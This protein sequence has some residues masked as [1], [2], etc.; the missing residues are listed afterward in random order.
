ML[1]VIVAIIIIPTVYTTL[2]L[3]S[4]WDPY[5]KVDNLPVA[6]VNQDKEVTFENQVL[7]IGDDLV[8]NLKDNDSLKF[9]F[10]DSTTANQGLEDGT[11]Y[12]VITIPQD[13]SFNATTVMDKNPQKMEL[14]YK[15]NPAHNYIASKMGENAV[16]RI[17]ESLNTEV[18]KVYLDTISDLFTEASDGMQKASDGAEKLQDGL[19]KVSDG[20]Q[21][22][23]EGVNKIATGASQ[24]AEN[25][26]AL[27]HGISQLSSGVHELSDGSKKLINGLNTLSGSIHS[28]IPSGSDIAALGK[29]LDAYKSGINQLNTALNNFSFGNQGK[30]IGDSLSNI[31]S[32]TQAAAADVSAIG[33]AVKTL[34]QAN[35]TKEQALALQTIVASATDLGGHLSTIA[36]DTKSVGNSLTSLTTGMSKINELKTAVNTLAKNS[37]TVLGNSKAAV[38][39]L[40]SGLTGV[41]QALNNQI[42]PGEMSLNQG[43][44][45]VQTAIDKKDG[46][47]DSISSYTAAVA[48][49]AEGTKTLDNKSADLIDGVTEL[50][51]GSKELYNALSDGTKEMKEAEI[52]DETADMMASP[53]D[54]DET[55][56]TKMENNGHAMSVYMM[57]V[58]LWVG[59]IAFCIMYP[60]SHYEGQLKS[61][62]VWFISKASVAYGVAI[63]QAV[64]MI[65]MLNRINGFKPEQMGRTVFIA[66]LA[67]V[68]FMSLLY[69]FNICFGKIGSFIMLIY[70]VIQLSGSAGTYPIELSG[71]FVAKIHKYLPFSYSIDAFRSTISGSGSIKEPVIVL[72][73]IFIVSTILTILIF[74]IRAKRIKNGKPQLFELLEKSG[75]A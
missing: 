5:G 58:A 3:G 69:F 61:G 55:K 31:G 29:G 56:V 52:K 51:D 62:F 10:V 67:S 65:F 11:Y 71:S 27:N 59:C 6:V 57:S 64:V 73:A 21:S 41:E 37:E 36:T 8:E 42:I 39:G 70:M 48:E 15:T 1:L 72:S 22:Y 4:M 66:C 50:T 45:K 33:N 16:A 75:L 12:M 46:L 49:I 44:N 19:T 18:T 13:F 20:A 26:A 35:L 32:S 17:K 28:T 63:L 14:T 9:D 68:A 43:I 23:T 40:Y 24:L 7:H 54:L 60:L 53:V 34:S 2:F 30:E 38:N 74:N 25:N 47:K